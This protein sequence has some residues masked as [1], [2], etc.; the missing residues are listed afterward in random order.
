[1]WAQPRLSR[2]EF[3]AKEQAYITAKASLTEQEAVRFFPLYFE[4]KDKVRKLNGAPWEKDKKL[5]QGSH[6][7]AEYGKVME[8][9]Y[10]NRIAADKLEKQYYYKFKAFLSCEKIYRIQKAEIDFHRELLKRR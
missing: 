3:R 8:E 10:N 5:C 2:E 7:D 9:A 4:M 6:S 1:M